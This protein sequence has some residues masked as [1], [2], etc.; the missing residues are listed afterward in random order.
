MEYDVDKIIINCPGCGQKLRLPL[1]NSSRVEIK[2]QRCSRE[3]NF[4]C[5]KYKEEQLGRRMWP[6]GI[7]FSAA[8]QNPSTCFLDPD[9]KSSIPSVDDRLGL[10][11]A[12]SGQ[13]A[14]VFKVKVS[15]GYKAVRCFTREV[16]DRAKRYSAIDEHFNKIKHI[17][18]INRLASYKY[19]S[20]GIIVNGRKYPC[21]FMEWVEGNNLDIYIEQIV[22]NK[23]ALLYLAD[24]WVR[25]IKVLKEAQIAH[26]DL[27]HGNIIVSQSGLKLRLVDFDGMYVPEM[28]GLRSCELGL[29]DYQS[30]LRTYAYF[31]SNLD[32]FSSLVIYVSILAIAHQPNLWKQFHGESLLIKQKDLKDPDNSAFFKSINSN[33]ARLKKYSD[34]LKTCCKKP[35]DQIPSLLDSIDV[36]ENGSL[37]AWMVAPVGA[38]VDIKTREAKVERAKPAKKV[39]NLSS[40]YNTNIISRSTQTQSFQTTSSAPYSKF[41][42]ILISSIF[43]CSFWWVII[44]SLGRWNFIWASI[45]GVVGLIIAV[46]RTAVGTRNIPKSVYALSTPTVGSGKYIGSNIKLVYHR[47]Q[48]EFVKKISSRNRVCFSSSPV[49]RYNNYRPCKVCFP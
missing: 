12:A 11:Y 34:L 1:I 46:N 38:F 33:D 27:Q 35:L 41:T 14:T 8:I 20:E 5:R 6:S 45:C 3:F 21:L 29:P 48:C 40:S 2:C 39:S 16:G 4:D 17:Q 28:N 44:S 49:A 23:E 13:F 32:N 47:L 31:K 37:P 19:E 30:P 15:G 36:E 43:I 18:G 25:L 10:P 22:G 42:T 7:D 26:G 24:E 9:L